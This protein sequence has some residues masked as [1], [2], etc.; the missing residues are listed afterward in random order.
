[1]T[2]VTWSC[3][4]EPSICGSSSSKLQHCGKHSGNVGKQGYTTGFYSI[5][6]AAVHGCCFEGDAVLKCDT[7]DQTF[8]ENAITGFSKRDRSGKLS[9]TAVWG[10]LSQLP[11]REGDTVTALI[12]AFPSSATSP[13]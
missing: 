1:M 8:C 10:T 11:A 6:A 5:C 12:E 3:I 9:A 4:V 2:T 13:F 7:Q